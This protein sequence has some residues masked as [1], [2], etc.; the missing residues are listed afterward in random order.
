MLCFAILALLP[1]L[2]LAQDRASAVAD[3]AATA[4]TASRI[5]NLQAQLDKGIVPLERFRKEG[6]EAPPSSIACAR[7]TPGRPT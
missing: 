1:T 3:A 2:C 5:E 7:N 4:Q 6:D